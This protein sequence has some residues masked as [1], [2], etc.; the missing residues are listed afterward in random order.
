MRRKRTTRRSQAETIR[1]EM[2]KAAHR[3]MEAKRNHQQAGKRIKIMV[4]ALMLIGMIGISIQPAQAGAW[5]NAQTYYNT[6]GD[7][8]VFRPIS[9]TDGLIYY[10]TKAKI[11]T[12]STKFQTLGWKFTVKNTN[13]TTLQTLYFKLNGNYMYQANTVRKGSYEYNLYCLSLYQLKNRMN[14]KASKAFQTGKASVRLD[15]C[16]TIVKNGSVKGCMNDQGTFSGSVYTTYQ[17]IASAANWSAATKQLL[18]SYFAKY[19]E[20]LFLNV[21]VIAGEGIKSVNGSGSYCYGTYVEVGA[22][23][24]VGYEFSNWSG[25]LRGGCR[26]DGF[27]VNQS[28]NCVAIGQLKLLRIYYHRNQ[29]AQDNVVDYQVVQYHK[30][31]AELEFL[32]W[33]KDGSQALGWAHS[34]SAKQKK[35]A[36]G[37]RISGKWI[38][39]YAPEVHLYAVWEDSDPDNPPTPPTPTPPTPP[40]PTPPTPTPIPPTPT[41]PTPTPTPN[42]TPEIKTEEPATNKVVR[43]RFISSKYFEDD[44]HH[45]IPQEQGGLASG[46]VWVTDPIRRQMLR[47]ALRH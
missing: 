7:S 26:Q 29:S 4:A 24:A 46:S 9:H 15:A 13:G 23:P 41:P 38:D 44:N 27:Y 33:R 43:C 30:N 22:I 5:D 28:G 17:G 16:M 11:A 8:V 39:Q 2:R 19:V 14:A 20:N 40:T 3:R 6:Y 18:H 47:Y 1:F 35:Y 31:G 12:T 21:N 42:P 32:Y 37:Q 34:S 45:L 36:F 25:M 10:A